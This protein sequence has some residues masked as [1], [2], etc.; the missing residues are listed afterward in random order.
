LNI[1]I[2]IRID[3]FIHTTK[4]LKM[5]KKL[6]LFLFVAFVLN[7]VNAQWTSMAPMSG[8]RAG[9]TSSVLEDG[10]VLVAGGWNYT[11]NLLTAEVYDVGSNSWHSVPDMSSQHYNGEAVTLNDG[12]VLIISGFNGTFN[13]EECE[14]FDATSETW[15]SGSLLTTG[16]SYF[17]ATKLSNG[18]VLVVGGYDGTDNLSS[19]EIYDPELNTWSAAASLNTGRSYHTASLLADG[20]LLVTGGFN[21]NAGYQLNLVEIYNPDL[22]TWTAGPNLNIGRD[23]H[24]ASVLSDGSVIVSG[25]RYFNG[26]MNYAY[27]GLMDV[28]KYNPTSNEWTIV[29]SLP[30][31]LSYHKQ[32][33]LSNGNVLAIAGVDSSNYSSSA[34]FTTFASETYEYDVMTDSW[35]ARP[36]LQD[37]RYEFAVSALGN[38]TALVTGGVDMSAE[39]YGSVTNIQKTDK[40]EISLTVAPNPGSGIIKVISNSDIKIV[41]IYLIDL[42]GN[43]VAVSVNNISNNGFTFTSDAIA[44][45][46]YILSIALKDGQVLNQRVILN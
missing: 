24:A 39:L 10:N 34:G 3:A 33:T 9:H 18:K 23:F 4:L 21:P 6:L 25:G 1:S 5:N 14:L 46:C 35:T 32:V 45:G 8:T 16:R 27:N 22:D 29:S 20:R 26:S 38:S 40:K 28:E 17:T 31:G 7:N 37:S 42:I 41:D 13:T 12:N 2:R 30:Q 11:S 44:T 15:S 36:M 19:C 43:K